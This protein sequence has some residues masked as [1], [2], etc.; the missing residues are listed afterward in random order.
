VSSVATGA[1][2]GLI[3]RARTAPAWVWLCALVVCALG[4]AYLASRRTVAPWIFYDEIVYSQLARSFAA[5]AHFAING[6]STTSYGFVYPILIAP[7]YRLF[8][9]IPDAYAAAKAINALLMALAAVPAYLLARRLLSPRLSLLAALLTV[10]VPSMVYVG[11]LMTENAF[12]PLYLTCVLVLVLVLERPTPLRTL[13]FLGAVAVAAATRVQALVFLP[14][15]LAAPLLLVLFRREPWRR[16][17]AYRWLYGLVCGGAVLGVLGQLARGRSPLS[18]LGAYQVLGRRHYDVVSVLRWT[19]SHA[20]ELDLYVGVVCVVAL[21][22]LLA[23]ARS[24]PRPVQTFLAA[25]VSCIVLTLVQVAAFASNII[26]RIEERNLFYVAPLFFIA[27]LAWIEQGLPRP[28]R[29]TAAIVVVAGSLPAFIPF[30]NPAVVGT[31]AAADTLMMHAWWWINE[32][33]GIPT[34]RLWLLALPLC[35]LAALF[36]G[37]VPRQWALA[38]PLLLLVYD[39]VN[40]QVIENWKHGVRQ[41]SIGALWQGIGV[42]ERDWIDRAT[43]GRAGSAAII[44]C[45]NGPRTGLSPCGPQVNAN[46]IWENQFFSRSVGQVYDLRE[47]TPG[48][49][50]EKPLRL[51]P[52]TGVYHIGTRNGPLLR[53]RY[54]VANTSLHLDGDIVAL[55]PHTLLAVIRPDGPLRTGFLGVYADSWTRPAAVYRRASCAAGSVLEL[56]LGSDPSLFR[57]RQTVV[58]REGG[59]V[60]GRAS[61]PPAT[62]GVRLRLPLH[63]RAGGCSVRLDVSPTAV[64]ARVLPASED[65]RRLGVRV[66]SYRY[67]PPAR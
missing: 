62:G 50:N 41:A 23:Q 53:S 61:V 1:R 28:R 56:T 67:L 2:P 26:H 54:V 58:A 44:W 6:Q 33:T 31:E 55:D 27:L 57:R 46:D 18:I 34:N 47:P 35:L 21:L 59:R 30:A 40:L 17:L 42:P 19:L 11:V 38:L 66:L 51:D 12:Y 9:S 37:L 36:A 29:R 14:A 22:M 7:A 24:L 20:A 3:A 60:V 4:A 13:L 10:T 8:G 65:T 39:G 48:G 25:A 43:G 5:S 64:P 63:P 16:L 49:I 32:T 45:G 52:A 15:A